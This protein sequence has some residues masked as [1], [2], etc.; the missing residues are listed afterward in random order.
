MNDRVSR[1][2]ALRTG[3][4]LAGTSGIAGCSA[5]PFGGGGPDLRYTDWLYAPG[6]GGLDAYE[7]V[8]VR[9]AGLAERRE[10]IGPLSYDRVSGVG[11][12]FLDLVDVEFAAVES[13]LA[14]RGT[15]AGNW[16]STTSVGSARPR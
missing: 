7:F 15:S 8:L 13:L 4:V 6:T 16:G 10:A 3:A 9:P 11:E 5:L 2:A 1:R 14:I 12:P